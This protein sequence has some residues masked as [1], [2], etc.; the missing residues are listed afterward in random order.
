MT[1]SHA[2]SR[3]AIFGAPIDPSA[4]DHPRD[5]VRA[6]RARVQDGGRRAHRAPRAVG[7]ARTAVTQGSGP[8]DGVDLQR[9]PDEGGG[10]RRQAA[11][12]HEP[13][14]IA[15]R[16]AT[17]DAARSTRRARTGRPPTAPPPRSSRAQRTGRGTARAGSP[18]RARRQERHDG[19]H[20]R[21]LQAGRRG[22][23]VLRRSGL[24]ALS[25]GRRV[26]DAAH[27]DRLGDARGAPGERDC[28]Q[29]ARP[30]RDA[31]DHGPAR[32][33]GCPARP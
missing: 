17:G 7:P 31:E 18:Q 26:Q 29:L 22:F 14:A 9:R 13:Q 20:G 21:L 10:E 1:G 2:R 23:R 6:R 24:V 15:P 4:L 28:F 30:D 5:V 19:C 3:R 12:R 11:D 25:P 32:S 16:P 27:R 33:S 8:S